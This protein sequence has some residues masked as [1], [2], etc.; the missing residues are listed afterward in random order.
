M[1]GLSRLPRVSM[2]MDSPA[3]LVLPVSTLT[4]MLRVSQSALSPITEMVVPAI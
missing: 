2:K 3:A 4:Q 1:S